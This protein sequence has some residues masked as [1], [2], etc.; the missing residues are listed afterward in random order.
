[1][2]ERAS[3]DSAEGVGFEPTGACAPAVF[4]TA[5]LNHSGTPPRAILRVEIAVS[6]RRRQRSAAGPAPGWRGRANQQIADAL[7]INVG[8]VKTDVKG[9]I[10]K[11][12]VNQGTQAVAGAREA[13]L[14]RP[15]ATPESADASPRGASDVGGC[16]CGPWR[17]S[18]RYR[19]I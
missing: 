5:P 9:I 14:M 8:T 18:A 10:G 15:P 3:C 16:A 4:K 13:D 19:A 6:A 2:R 11:R 17:A 12:R 1:M 7:S